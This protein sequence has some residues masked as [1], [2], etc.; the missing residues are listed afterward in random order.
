MQGTERESA[1]TA[2]RGGG[3]SINSYKIHI[4]NIFKSL[5]FQ[6]I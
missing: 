1:S 6:L 4:T 3:N 2:F 5:I